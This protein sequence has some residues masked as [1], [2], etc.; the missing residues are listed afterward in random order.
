[1][2]TS[3]IYDELK[4]A[5]V[6]LKGHFVYS[7]GLHGEDYVDKYALY[8]RPM[9]TAEICKNFIPLIKNLGIDTIVG[10]EKGGIYLSQWTAFWLSKQLQK[11][12]I[13]I[14]AYKAGKGFGIRPEY[15]TDVQRK[16][17]LIVEDVITTV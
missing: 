12:V 2:T 5:G 15:L 3:T 9:R 16:R 10:P 13:S 7:H 17:I 1:M 8:K 14:S 6:F 11:E 4:N